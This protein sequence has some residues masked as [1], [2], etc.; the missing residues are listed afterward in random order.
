MTRSG[1]AA[2]APRRSESETSTGD[3]N[4]PTR[5]P[6]T[7]PPPACPSKQWKK[8][9]QSSST[10]KEVT[11]LICTA[12]WN[13][14]WAQAAQHHPSSP[15]ITCKGNLRNWTA[16]QNNAIFELES[17][18]GTFWIAR[19]ALPRCDYEEP[20]DLQYTMQS[21]VAVM[22]TVR[23][24]TTIPVPDRLHHGLAMGQRLWLP[25]YANVCPARS[26]AS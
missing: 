7:P 21:E 22:N 8:P 4:Y 16:G 5:A 25:V 12:S 6:S 20:Y 19:E 24:R 11:Q 23:E 1:A 9:D 2:P 26:T 13:H 17:S 10:Y 18:D 15:D 14:I 3:D